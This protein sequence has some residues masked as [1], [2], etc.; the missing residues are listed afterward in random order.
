MVV[1]ERTY[2]D[3]AHDHT[4]ND[5]ATTPIEI[6]KSQH[7]LSMTAKSMGTI[8]N[9]GRHQSDTGYSRCIDNLGSV[10]EDVPTLKLLVKIHKPLGEEGHPQSRPFVAAATG[11]SS[12]AG[13]VLA[14]F[15][16][17]M[18]I[19]DLPRMEDKSTKEV[20]A[21]LE[22]AETTIREAG[23]SDT[24]VGSLDVQALYPSLHHED[25]AEIVAN[26]VKESSL[27]LLGIDFCSC[28]VF[29]ASNLSEQEVKKEGLGSLLPKRM[30]R[31]GA[32]PDSTMLELGKKKLE[33][34]GQV[35]VEAEM[36]KQDCSK[37]RHTDVSALSDVDKRVLISKVVKVAILNVFHNH[38]YQFAGVTFRQL[39]GAPIGLRL[40]SVIATIIM[41][42]WVKRF[43]ASIMDAGVRVHLLAKY[44]DDINVILSMICL[45]TRWVGDHL[46]HSEEQERQD[47]AASRSQ[48]EN[49]MLCI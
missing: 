47:E 5:V 26:F 3:M 19:T 23:W 12:R 30:H 1:D 31:M 40:T 37:W 44:V 38:M 2:L 20:L 36:E 48:E 46:E 42:V 16:E 45:G 6:R 49:T 41:D 13:D 32:R 35:E 28:Q 33:G 4:K 43:L 39:L 17:P 8:L 24:M 25:S 22:E 15:L 7:I 29:L 27:E 14:D 10:S 11:L 21:Q 9:L 18:V 34:K